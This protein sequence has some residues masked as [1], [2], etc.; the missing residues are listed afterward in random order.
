VNLCCECVN[1]CY[2]DANAGNLYS[3][4]GSGNDQLGPECIEHN[5]HCTSHTTLPGVTG[6]I[7]RVTPDPVV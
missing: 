2:I 6:A 3:I 1:L 4:G 7:P 5:G